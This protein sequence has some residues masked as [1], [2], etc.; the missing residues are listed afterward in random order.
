MRLAVT[1]NI[2]NGVFELL[3]RQCGP[4]LS[5]RD[6]LLELDFSSAGFGTP[7]GLVPFAGLIRALKTRGV[8]IAVLQYPENAS[9]CGYYCRMD[10]FKRIGTKSPCPQQT[11]HDGE[12]RFIE[13][14]ELRHPDITDKMELKFRH[15]LQRLPKGTEATEQSRSSF[16]DAS[17]ELV[18]NTRHAYNL[19]LD[20]NIK[21]APKALLQAQFYPKAE[22]V[23]F[24][25]CD[26]GIGIKRSMDGAGVKHP[27]HLDAVNSAL[28]LRNKADT[29][30]GR[31]LGLATLQ[32][33]IRNNGGILSIRSGD[34]L[35][36]QQGANF[37]V[38]QQLP[39][40]DGTIVSLEINV[41]KSS[42]LSDIWKR[43][44]K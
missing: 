36:V 23:K 1:G 42:D 39:K 25:V 37:S 17:G 4:C 31:G 5:G 28:G 26:C 41:K 19:A 27:S 7:S 43:F 21:T 9:I 29:S 15:L 10:F 11:R 16:I 2:D 38:T 35:K 12:G 24:C 32:S 33:F 40:W 44:A 30:D 20:A 13:I 3:L 14:T 8:E 18:A 22:T 34:A 6:K